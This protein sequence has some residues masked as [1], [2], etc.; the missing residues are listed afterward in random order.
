MSRP[1]GQYP[2]Q[3]PPYPTSSPQPPYPAY[4][5]APPSQQQP[6]ASITPGY[7]PQ[8]SQY[9]QPPQQGGYSRPPAPVPQYGGAPQQ[10]SY[11]QPPPVQGQ[12]SYA[13]GYN[14]AGVR[15]SMFDRIVL[16]TCD[17]Y[18]TSLD[19]LKLTSRLIGLLRRVSS[20][21]TST[22]T[23]RTVR[24]TPSRRRSRRRTLWWR[25]W[26]SSC[27]LWPRSSGHAPGTFNIQKPLDCNNSRATDSVFLPSR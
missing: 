19:E 2:G 1:Y 18:F 20:P 4:S 8:Q 26:R 5:S 15:L 11:G 22:R 16:N 23:S 9:N 6:P 12:Q 21:G 25:L 27:S 24:R 13:P 10:Q 14:N 17:F 3:Q 7:P